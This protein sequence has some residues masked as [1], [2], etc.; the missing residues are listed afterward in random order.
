M[1]RSVEVEQSWKGF[2]LE[3]KIKAR[4]CPTSGPRSYEKQYWEYVESHF[5]GVYKNWHAYLNAKTFVHGMDKAGLL[6]SYKREMSSLVN[7]CHPKMSPELIL[8]SNREMLVVI[9]ESF[10][11]TIPKLHLDIVL[12]EGLKFCVPKVVNFAEP[13]EDPTWLFSEGKR[14]ENI[15]KLKCPMG[16]S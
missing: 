11:D 15:K 14:A 8:C 16:G 13:D 6:D 10:A 2:C 4:N 7:F 9:A 1:D 12:T 3:R 5:K